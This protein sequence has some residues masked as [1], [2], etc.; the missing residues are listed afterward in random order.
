L[1]GGPSAWESAFT[2]TTDSMDN[3]FW[4]R[5]SAF[6]RDSFLLLTTDRSD[7]AGRI[8]AD[9]TRALHPPR[10]GQ[11]QIRDFDFTFITLHL[12]FAD[13]DTAE[14]MRELRAILDYLDWYFTQTDHDPDVVVCG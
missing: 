12:R 4:H 8:I 5:N 2:D 3:G 1:P 13:G 11:F 7:S 10:V 9:E 14:S 6:L